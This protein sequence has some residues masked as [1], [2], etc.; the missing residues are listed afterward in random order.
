[1]YLP[2][3]YSHG[4]P[5]LAVKSLLYLKY[6]IV[7]AMFMLMFYKHQV[8]KKIRLKMYETIGLI[9]IIWSLFI[10]V[11]SYFS[12]KELDM[13]RMQ[14]FLFPLISYYAGRSTNVSYE[15]LLKLCR[16]IVVIFGVI[17]CYAI[18]DIVFIDEHLWRSVLQQETYLLDIK[19]YSGGIIDGLI[20]NFYFDPYL[21]RIR[22]AI[23]T[24]GDPLSFAYAG[25]LPLILL[26]IAGKDIVSSSFKMRL[27]LLL[28]GLAVMLSLTRAVIL[29]GI[30]VL[31]IRRFFKRRFNM[32]VC[33][34][35]VALVFIISGA[36][37]I[38]QTLT[39]LKDSS[40]RG[41]LE[42]LSNLYHLNVQS[43][44][45]GQVVESSSESIIFES[46][47]LNYIVTLGF[48]MACM[49]YYYIYRILETLRKS[50]KPVANAIGL[51]G[52][53]GLLTSIIFS[54]SFFSFTGFGMF[55][56]FAGMATGVAKRGSHVGN[57]ETFDY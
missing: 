8:L 26:L 54:E 41:H 1:M 17:S 38:I 18:L 33:C 49:F 6:G 43:F 2:F 19:G 48:I 4:I 13:S 24:T 7:S 34:I 52:T 12:G 25:V 31:V 20:G 35:G 9:I 47:F 57:I 3:L 42:S 39:G 30:A 44:L 15:M 55:W 29:S 11:L 10:V 21:L 36:G 16:V 37:P 5:A 50:P 46:G 23:G 22:R 53:V 32:V 40:T 14:L 51:S 27:G 56:F 28:G 45:F